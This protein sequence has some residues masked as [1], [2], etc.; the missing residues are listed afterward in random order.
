MTIIEADGVEHEPL[1]VDSLT[2]HAGTY[3]TCIAF[4]KKCDNLMSAH[5]STIFLYR[6]SNYDYFYASVFNL[7]GIGD[8][9]PAGR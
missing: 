8:D 7:L 9:G 2:I 6:E 4:H 1:T 5:R 3:S